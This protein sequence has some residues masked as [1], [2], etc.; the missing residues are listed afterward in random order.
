MPI[1]ESL[2]GIVDGALGTAAA[3]TKTTE[4][5]VLVGKNTLK[6]T[7]TGLEAA[8]KITE[9]SG[10]LGKVGINAVT[11]VTLASGDVAAQLTTDSGKVA[12]TSLH[13]LDDQLKN[14][15]KNT[16]TLLDLT[17]TS[18]EK[19]SPH[20]GDSLGNTSQISS[21][22][23]KSASET[24]TFGTSLLS[25]LLSVLNY[26]FQK[27]SEKIKEIQESNAKPEN[28]RKQLK[29][30]LKQNFVSITDS[31]KADFN[32]GLNNT[33]KNVDEL[34]ELFQ[35]LGCKTI[36]WTYNCEADIT[37]QL[38][39]IRNLH[40]VMKSEK[41]QFNQQIDTVFKQFNIRVDQIIAT[42][43][44]DD[45]KFD[46]IINKSER[47]QAEIL[48]LV[49]EKYSKILENYNVKLDKIESVVKKLESEIMDELEPVS[50]TDESL[51]EK[52]GGRKSTQSRKSRKSNRHRKTKRSNTK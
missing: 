25:S 17:N 15:N 35:K 4:Q 19:M 42:G 48:A 52:K 51:V 13:A 39:A 5:G 40:N 16:S 50:K 12:S 34:I 30:T 18:V 31:T 21:T 36:A 24:I 32:H 22:L 49:T 8:D 3:V 23:T 6:L 11:K 20:L 46:D 29:V 43:S 10:E 26:P 45:D 41:Y 28:K 14:V 47:I 37:R 44:N 7:N 2:L 9:A 27:A 33:I 38:N 1:G